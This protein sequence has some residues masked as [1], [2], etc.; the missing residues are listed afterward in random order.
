[1]NAFLFTPKPFY[2]SMQIKKGIIE[3]ISPSRFPKRI[4]RLV[5]PGFIS[6]HIHTI[7]THARNTAENLE[8]LDWLKKKIWPFEASLTKKTAYASS[9]TG[10][11]ECLEFGITTILDMATTRHTHSVFEA[12]RDSG[13]RAFI[14]KALMDQGPKSLIEKDPLSEVFDL[15][16]DWHGFDNKRL[17]VTLSPRFALSCSE[18]LLREAGRLSN[19]LKLIQH[20]HISENLKECEWIEEHF[21]F[22]NVELLNEVGSLNDLSVLAHSVHVSKK[23]IALLKKNG[24]SISHCPVS[25]L[26]LAS[27]IADIKRLSALNLSLGV[28]GAACNNLLDPFFE[29]RM[30]HLLSRSLHGLKGV[31][32]ENIF[33]MATVGGARALHSE[34]QFG[35]LQVGKEAD[36][37][38]VN[39]PERVYFNPKFPY[40]SLLHS[41]VASNIE[42]V[43]VKGRRVFTC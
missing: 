26:K 16:A 23:D 20:S 27:G 41:I 15:L 18:K 1:M 38:V 25:N 35:T 7:Q 21:G 10:M 17:Q 24:C 8:L 43:F 30:A 36:Y 28:D 2:G 5:L 29:M 11:R 19:E 4:D 13:I 9:F 33:K 32:A 40:E 37:L 22:S 42:S 39:V 12:A 31:S 14:G 3:R 6:T 34:K